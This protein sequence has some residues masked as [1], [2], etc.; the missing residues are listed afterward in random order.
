MTFKSRI[1]IYIRQKYQVHSVRREGWML[2]KTTTSRKRKDSQRGAAMLEATAIILLMLGLLFLVVD[3]S[4]ALFTKATL[5]EAAEAGVRFA[6]TDRV[7]SGQ[8]YMNDSIKQV[9]QQNSLGMLSGANGACKIAINY[10]NAVT[11][12]PSTGNPG[13]VVEVS[14]VGYNYKPIG[15]LKS[16]SPISITASSSDVLEAC[17]L[18]G[19]PPV[20]DPTPPTCP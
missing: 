5:Q 8:T 4:L 19:C 11:G 10:T 9:V 14:V 18:A 16:S 1:T 15:I 17:P 7:A 2:M 12:Q 13:D 20:A 3:L 6:V